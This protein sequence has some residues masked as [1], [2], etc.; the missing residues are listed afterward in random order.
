[1]AKY[2]YPRYDTN[3]RDAGSKYPTEIRVGQKW[4]A[5]YP[6]VKAHPELFGDEPSGEPLPR[7]FIPPVAR[8][9]QASA[10]PGERR[11]VRRDD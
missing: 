1:M 10:S 7:G 8:V 9:E 3:V 11:S 2:K 6:L 4:H 5:D